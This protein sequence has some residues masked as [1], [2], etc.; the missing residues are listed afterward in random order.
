M[1]S[2]FSGEFAGA[3]GCL[4]APVSAGLA[5]RLA[6][7]EGL[8]DPERAAIAEAAER[9]ILETVH[10]KVSRVLLLELNAARLSGRLSAEDSAG[11]WQE[12]LNLA[13]DLSSGAP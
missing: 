11:R 5:A 12:F 1:T 7:V 9:A 13:D 3:L 2:R 6:A 8:S 4:A 10:R